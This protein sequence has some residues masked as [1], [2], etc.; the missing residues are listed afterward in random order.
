M[1]VVG[2]SGVKAGGPKA[3]G[4]GAQPV[5]SEIAL[6]ESFLLA[7]E[8]MPAATRLETVYLFVSCTVGV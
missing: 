6:S 4:G 8:T 5:W 7:Y 1:S 3:G 2:W